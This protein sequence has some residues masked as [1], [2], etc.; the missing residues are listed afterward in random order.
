MQL[1]DTSET[2]ICNVSFLVNNVKIPVYM[3]LVLQ[4][5]NANIYIS[6]HP[7]FLTMKCSPLDYLYLLPF[8]C[9][10]LIPCNCI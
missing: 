1:Y 3:K 5:F 7:L 2:T 4:W 8:F 6:Q 9:V 10:S